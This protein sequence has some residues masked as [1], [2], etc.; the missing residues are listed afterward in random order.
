MYEINKI[1]TP[2][3]CTFIHQL[4]KVGIVHNLFVKSSRKSANRYRNLH[5]E[6]IYYNMKNKNKFLSQD[7]YLAQMKSGAPGTRL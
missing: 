5:F 3:P 7:E 2:R 4:I 6:S 1:N